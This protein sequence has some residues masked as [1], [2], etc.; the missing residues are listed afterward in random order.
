[1]GPGDYDVHTSANIIHKNVTGVVPWKRPE[2]ESKAAKE[3]V[4]PPG[5]GE[6]DLMAVTQMHSA[7]KRT[8]TS[9]F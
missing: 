8:G 3:K 1:M 5:P 6:Y 9:V 4:V 2:T 7:A